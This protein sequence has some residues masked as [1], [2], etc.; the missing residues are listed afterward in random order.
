LSQSDI[1]PT[2]HANREFSV[3]NTHKAAFSATKILLPIDFSPSSEIALE[4]AT[5]LALQ[6]H[7]SIHLV[8]IIPEIPDF[9]GSDFFPETAVLQERRETIELKLGTCEQLLM[10]KGVQT[11]FSIEIGND[12]VGALMRVI[13]REK[14]DMVVISTHGLSG[15]RPLIV[16]SIAQQV[17]K[18]VNCTLLLLQSGQHGAAVEESAIDVWEDSFIPQ[19]VATGPIGSTVVKPETLSEKRIDRVAEELAE[20]GARTEQHYDQ[21]HSLFTK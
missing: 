15:W 2:L 14:A 3:S 4:A 7:A 5:G 16:G 11:A 6:F 10:L 21:A 20:R 1:Q 8:H 17:I 13:N 18:Q 9:N 12:I 19:V